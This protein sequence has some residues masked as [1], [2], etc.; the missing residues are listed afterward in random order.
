[1]NTTVF[2]SFEP[3]R[4]SRRSPERVLSFL[5]AG[6]LV[7]GLGA[8]V[9]RLEPP[10]VP[11]KEKP[12]QITFLPEP[13]VEAPSPPQPVQ[14]KPIAAAAAPVVP[15]HLKKIIVDTPPPVKPL[16]AP[17]ETSL[18]PL[19]EADPSE[20][21]GV[22]VVGG[23]AAG[24]PAGLE[25][26]SLEGKAGGIVG[27][28]EKAPL[29]NVAAI[30]MPD[31]ATPPKP[32][33]DNAVPEYPTAAKAAGKTG[34]VVLKVIIDEDGKVVQ[35]QKMRGDEPFVAAATAAVKTW[36]YHPAMQSGKKLKVFRL[37]KI[38]F[39]LNP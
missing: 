4:A 30:D 16:A 9:W 26:G 24:D 28:D 27:G 10:K 31:D 21:K 15:K 39:Q 14:T 5:A 23:D 2:T 22:M 33:D 19:A 18:Q 25:G 29:A 17:V 37:V 32:F 8:A 34:T 11:P 1:M 12:V 13:V 3:N 7:V 20:D 36:R 35:V 6:M 38:P